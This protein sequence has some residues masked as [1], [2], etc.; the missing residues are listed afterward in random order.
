MRLHELHIPDKP[1]KCF[2]KREQLVE[3]I[4]RGRWWAF[5]R[6]CLVFKSWLGLSFVLRPLK[7]YLQFLLYVMEVIISISQSGWW[8]L[9]KTAYLMS[10][11]RAEWY[12][13]VGNK[14]RH[15]F[16]K[17]TQK[18]KGWMTWERIFQTVVF[19]ISVQRDLEIHLWSDEFWKLHSL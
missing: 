3:H 15:T 14:W 12:L 8:L 18:W 16:L 10:T 19:K 13:Q 2:T 11:H 6:A 1:L 17:S 4:I 9:D 7:L 5:Q